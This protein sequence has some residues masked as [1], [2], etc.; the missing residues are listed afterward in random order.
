MTQPPSPATAAINALAIDLLHA[1]AKPD[2]N[3]VLS[4]YSIQ[5]ALAMAYAGAA[6]AT[7]EEMAK[8]LHYPKDE[9]SLHRSFAQSRQALEEVVQRSEAYARQ[10]AGFASNDPVVLTVANRL[11][12]QS[13]YDFREAFQAFLKTNYEAPL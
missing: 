13:G 10:M 5:T 7:R 12:G 9:A 4:P 3:A 1:T 6:G 11:F 8:V 2:A